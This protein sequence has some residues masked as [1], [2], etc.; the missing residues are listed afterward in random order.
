MICLCV[1]VQIFAN[2]YIIYISWCVLNS[3]A[4]IKYAIEIHLNRLQASQQA[5]QQAR[6]PPS[7]YTKYVVNS[8]LKENSPFIN[9]MQLKRAL[10]LLD[11]WWFHR[12]VL[13]V[14]SWR[15]TIICIYSYDFMLQFTYF[16]AMFINC[17]EVFDH[18]LAKVLWKYLK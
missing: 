11:L 9:D 13:S 10:H 15:H 5:S 2:G 7:H 14:L 8:V 17:T 16:I 1:F 4:C 18:F 6:K 12:W 3:N